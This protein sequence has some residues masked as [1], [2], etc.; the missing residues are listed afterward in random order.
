[1]Q[2]KTLATSLTTATLL[3]GA[4][5]SH[6]TDAEGRFWLGGGAGGVECPKFIASME[7]ARSV[8]IGTVRY[9]RETQAFTMYLL[10]FRS[11]FNKSTPNTC[12]IFS[13]EENDYPWLSWMEN[14]CRAH[15]SSRF[16]DAVVALSDER[17]PNRQ[18]ACSK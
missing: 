13:G 10:G 6:A 11:G 17:F 2:M 8:G 9:V 7:K 14:W 15:P 3:C 12:D 16:G 4:Q 5:I 18:Q 1:M